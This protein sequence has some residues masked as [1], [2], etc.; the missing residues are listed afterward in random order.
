MWVVV[1]VVVVWNAV[2]TTACRVHMTL[3]WKLWSMWTPDRANSCLDIFSK[4]QAPQLSIIDP[5]FHTMSPLYHKLTWSN[6]KFPSI[7]AWRCSTRHLSYNIQ[8]QI[9]L[10]SCHEHSSHKPRPQ[11]RSPT[12]PRSRHR[13]QISTH[14][15]SHRRLQSR[16]S[17]TTSPFAP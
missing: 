9:I 12:K 1:V 13:I 8:A 11:P 15:T 4:R 16:P 10:L 5:P 3:V 6:N 17:T 7:F 14:Q 2:N